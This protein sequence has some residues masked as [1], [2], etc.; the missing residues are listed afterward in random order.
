MKEIIQLAKQVHLTPRESEQW[1]QDFIANNNFPLIDGKRVTFFYWNENS[2]DAVY[3]LHWVHGLESRQEFRRLPGTNAF[4]LSLELPVAARVEYKFEIHRNGSRYWS[5]DP[6]NPSK[7]YDPFGSNSVCAMEGYSVPKWVHTNPSVRQGR[8]EEFTIKSTAFGD[9]RKVTVYLPAEYKVKKKYPLL[10]C[11]DG[12]D[13]RKYS[14]IVNILDN[15]IY[16]HNVIPLIVAFI[17]GHSRNIEYGANPQQAKFIVEDILPAME[18]KYRIS[19]GPE[20]RAIMGASF[21]AVSSLYAAWKYPGTFKKLLLQSGSFA[22]TDIG[23]HGRGELWDPVV[24]F[25][26][27]L[28]EHPQILQGCRMYMSCGVFESLIYYNRS[29]APIFRDNGVVLRYMESRD[30]HNWINWRDRLREGLSWLFPGHLRMY[31]E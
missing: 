27:A 7:A 29:L 1:I 26:N 22:F 24:E 31:Y 5:R 12:H 6:F 19:P 16:E 30:G 18:R 4:W 13:Y 23:E 28:R 8:L 14:N 3:L 21:G 20:N 2:V 10:I 15:L 11:H 25:V 17:D 9:E